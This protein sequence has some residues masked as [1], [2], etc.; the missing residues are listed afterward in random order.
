MFLLSLSLIGIWWELFVGC[1]L[2]L[3]LIF[4]WELFLKYV[5]WW[6]SVR[7]CRYGL[8]YW[9]V[10][11]CMMIN[12]FFVIWVVVLFMIVKICLGFRLVVLKLCGCIMFVFERI[13]YLFCCFFLEVI[14]LDMLLYWLF[15]F[16]LF[17]FFGFDEFVFNL[18]EF[19]KYL[20]WM[21]FLRL[22]K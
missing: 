22:F 4:L 13:V 16:V 20:S 7:Y 8:E 5:L 2:I 11:L 12:V 9:F 1:L 6:Y 18:V 15:F 10:V 21:W 3:I 19:D 17:F 14:C